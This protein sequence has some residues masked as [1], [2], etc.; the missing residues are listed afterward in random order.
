MLTRAAILNDTLKKKRRTGMRT[1]LDWSER[2]FE[3]PEDESITHFC[4]DGNVTI[5]FT[6]VNSY[7]LIA[8]HT[9]NRLKDRALFAFGESPCT[10][11]HQQILDNFSEKRKKTEPRRKAIVKDK[12][13]QIQVAEGG[14]DTCGMHYPFTGPSN[15]KRKAQVF[16]SGEKHPIL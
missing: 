1:Y 9:C 11:C 2:R 15:A 6:D 3:L 12:Q 16:S 8:C 7:D 10:D 13:P 14:Y 4:R 5:I